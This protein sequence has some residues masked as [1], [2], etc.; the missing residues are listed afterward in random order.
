VLILVG[1]NVCIELVF[2]E[3]GPQVGKKGSRTRSRATENGAVGWYSRIL[4]ARGLRGFGLALGLALG[5]FEWEA[6]E[7]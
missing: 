1:N 4:F 3:K 2:G 6:E 5:I 7:F